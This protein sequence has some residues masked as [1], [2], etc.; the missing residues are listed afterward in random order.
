[1]KELI[2][3]TIAM[4]SYKFGCLTKKGIK[5]TNIAQKYYLTLASLE[6]YTVLSDLTEKVLKIMFGVLI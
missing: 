3:V 1:M 5:N 6:L 2:C 4:H